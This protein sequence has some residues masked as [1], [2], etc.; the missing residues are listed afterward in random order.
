MG[1]K[2]WKERKFVLK[3]NG[4]LYYFIPDEEMLFQS[5]GKLLANDAVVKTIPAEDSFGKTNA[6][7]IKTASQ[8]TVLLASDDPKTAS[9]WIKIIEEMGNN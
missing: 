4:E 8:E 3:K 7:E 2:N 9:S 6:F 1:L 5:N